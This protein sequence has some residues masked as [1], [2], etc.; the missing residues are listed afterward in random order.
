MREILLNKSVISL[1]ILSVLTLV[2]LI[3]F[4]SFKDK[5]HMMERSIDMMKRK[6]A[7]QTIEV[8]QSNIAM[9][10]ING[11]DAMQYMAKKMDMEPIPLNRVKQV[12]LSENRI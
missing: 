2:H 4:F 11:G 8:E 9:M 1:I 5:A 12:Y 6:I 3:V 10:K 7:K